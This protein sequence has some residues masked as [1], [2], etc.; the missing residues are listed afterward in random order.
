MQGKLALS[1]IQRVGLYKGRS[2]ARLIHQC[3]SMFMYGDPKLFAGRQEQRPCPGLSERR[4]CSGQNVLPECVNKEV[5]YMSSNAQTEWCVAVDFHPRLGISIHV[6][7]SPAVKTRSPAIYRAS[8]RSSCM[9]LP[10]TRRFPSSQWL[11]LCLQ[12]TFAG[13]PG[14]KGRNRLDHRS[15]CRRL[16]WASIFVHLLFSAYA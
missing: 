14:K 9:R 5:K 4:M 6:T 3:A 10:L 8:W 13:R 7:R 11:G 1:R 12:G 16:T 2:E 15:C